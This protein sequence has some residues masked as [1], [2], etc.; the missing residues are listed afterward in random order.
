M[1][2]L[3]KEVSKTCQNIDLQMNIIK[4][5]KLQIKNTIHNGYRP[6]MFPHLSAILRDSTDTKVTSPTLHFRY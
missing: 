3:W 1:K 6:Y 4:Y 2:Y 5:N